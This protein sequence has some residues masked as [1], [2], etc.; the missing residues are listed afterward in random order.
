M[1]LDRVRRALLCRF[2]RGDGFRRSLFVEDG[3]CQK[4]S[5]VV[6]RKEC[7]DLVVCKLKRE[8]QLVSKFTVNVS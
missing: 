7:T 6:S 4:L 1:M 5:Y 2:I 8:L 3:F